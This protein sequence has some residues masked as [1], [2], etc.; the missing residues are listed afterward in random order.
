AS[1]DIPFDPTTS[2]LNPQTINVNL[3]T[4]GQ[5]SGVTQFDSASA[6]VSAGVNGAL[7]GGL[8]GVSVGT[9]GTVVASFD[10]GVQRKV[11]QIPLA[12]FANPD[13]LTETTGNSYLQ[14]QD[15]GA[16]SIKPPGVGGAGAINGSA[17]E[18]STVDLAKEFTDL[19]TTQRAYSAATR[20]ITTAD[21]MLQE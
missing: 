11:Y 5:I 15:S 20:I 21:D 6:I 4:P 3:G 7:F 2:G 10:N 8:A 14:S 19:I 18:S 13:G 16:V 1:L 12:P 17:L 9:D